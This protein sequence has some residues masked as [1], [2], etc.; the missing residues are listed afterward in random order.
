MVNDIEI[1]LKELRQL[2]ELYNYQY[3]VQDHPSV[4]D[5]EYDRLFSELT[6]LERAYPQYLTPDSPT[7]RV[8]ASPKEG[9]TEIVHRLPMLSLNNGFSEEDVCNFDRR[10]RE[11]LS[12]DQVYYACEP[13]FD[14]L[15]VSLI[16][17]NGLLTQGSTRG[18]GERGED[19]TL[20]L[21]TIRS[22]PLRLFTNNPPSILE[23]RGE[24]LMFK[25]DFDQLNETQ[26]EKGEK[27]FANPR[28]AAAGA[29]RQ[30]DSTLTAQRKLSFFAYGLGVLEGRDHPITHSSLMDWLASMRF[31]VCDIRDVVVGVEG[32]IG[33]FEKLN[34][35]RPTLPYQIDGVV[36]KV[37][38]FIQQQQLGFVSRAPRF[39]LAHKFPA[40]EAV[41]EVV[42]IDVQVG[43]TGALTPVA[44][45]K[46]VFVGGV[47]VTNATLHNE[48]E[49]KRKDVRVGD[50][51]W[52]RRAGDVIPE[53]V[54]VI[55]EK[56][57]AGV[58]TFIMPTHCPVCGS[59]V[60]RQQDE[61]VLRCSGGLYCPA[62][63]KQS[64][65]HFC[66]RRAMNIEGLGD[67]RV[68]QFVD[69]GILTTPADIYYLSRDALKELPLFG[70]KSI[71]NLMD[72]I[73]KSKQT[74]LPRFIFALGIR[75]VG[76]ATA[77]DL[78]NYFGDIKSLM[79]ANQEQLLAVKDVGPVIAESIVDFF[80]EEHNRDVINKLLQAGI[81]WPHIVTIQSHSCSGK[82]FVLTGTLPHLSRD[83]AKLKIEEIGGKVSS[84]VSGKTHFVVA[85]TEAG[86]K[87]DKAIELG[88]KILNEDEFLELI[89][90]GHEKYE[91]N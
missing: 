80:A 73:E 6:E 54:G 29:L 52:V 44:R 28:N 66:H 37:N 43:R 47:T 7:Q 9:F 38:D 84:S 35:L 77:K 14:G 1:K 3:Y 20:N 60:F 59:S 30:L 87:L 70:D 68:D 86:S 34:V 12:R 4:P 15:A 24:V 69:L 45:L 23:V 63:R 5:A 27:L 18:D 72:A 36:Y 67:K 55:F 88:I 61:A 65:V 21:K 83:E 22:I 49:L 26:R 79:A 10:V 51:V 16:Y 33:Y 57:P 56:R 40:E 58:T 90:T 17:E 75:N 39:A 50:S 85:G 78:A 42:G 2:I 82:T 74:T 19:V 89:K 41:T 13:K 76:E 62:Q 25:E 46:P 11:G 64:I 31:P 81:H 8:G 71:D 32:L 48:D 91:T 53:V